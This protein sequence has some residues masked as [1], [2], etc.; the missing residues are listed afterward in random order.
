MRS[1]FDGN[2]LQAKDHRKA[3]RALFSADGGFDVYP[4]PAAYLHHDGAVIVAN[5]EAARLAALLGFDTGQSFQ[6][7]L[8]AAIRGGVAKS[9][10]IAVADA[11]ADGAE[12]KPV[13]FDFTVLPVLSGET[14]LVLGRDTTL[15]FAFRGAL[16]E[17]WQRYKEMVEICGDFCWETD[18]DGRFAFVSPSG[19][20]GFS[21]EELIGMPAENFIDPISVDTG[22]SPFQATEAV[23]AVDI[24]MRCADGRSACLET[25]ARPITGA[26]GVRT[27]A[28][29]VC[30]DVST[31][32]DRATELARNQEREHQIAHIMRAIRDEFEPDRM[33]GIAVEATARAVGAVGCRVFRT[34]AEDVL[35]EAASHGGSPPTDEIFASALIRARSDGRP[36]SVEQG[37]T[38]LLCVATSWH[39]AVNGVVV[40][41]RAADCGLWTSDDRA[42]VGDVAVHLGVA[43]QQIR[44]QLELEALS[45]TDGLTGLLN[46]RAFVS[47]LET[48]MAR[49][50]AAG[51]LFYVDLDNFKPVNDLHGH[52]KGDEA[53]IAVAEMLTAWIRPGDLV[54][55]FG[56][57]E[58]A[59]WLE[60][61]NAETAENRAGDL[62]AAS[63]I[64]QEF[65][66][67]PDRPLGISI[68]V[69]VRSR[70]SSESLETLTG[71]A[72]AAMY[73]IKNNGKAGF[74]ISVEPVEH[75]ARAVN[76]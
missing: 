22:A 66:G 71:R 75:T 5:D 67:A 61:T 43:L 30:R 20:L 32:R 1:L 57:D 23:T 35:L 6:P 69:A 37:D 24:W 70:E 65:S 7:D 28:R 74:V 21:P 14:A 10:A 50:G 62:L 68:G 39:H 44:Y 58:F 54:A 72:D 11:S 3:L 73:N 2:W 34:D 16:S 12:D 42:F 18:G 40:L 53:L 15:E 49:D 48:R 63:S 26:G 25:S 51:A 27:G 29:G 41:W 4:G 8:G 55:R 31:E 52:Q 46:R 17:S 38:T 60:R 13:T 33:L 59:L 9:V 56:G 64:L 47:E 19:V 76:Q 45:R 36:F